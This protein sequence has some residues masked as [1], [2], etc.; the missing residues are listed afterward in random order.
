MRLGKCPPVFLHTKRIRSKTNQPVAVCFINMVQIMLI[1]AD[2]DR[3]PDKRIFIQHILHPGTAAEQL[4]KPGRLHI[5]MMIKQDQHEILPYPVRPELAHIMIISGINKMQPIRRQ[6]GN[7]FPDG[8]SRIFI[9]VPVH[10]LQI[11]QSNP[12]VRLL[13]IEAFLLIHMGKI[14]QYNRRCVR[15]FF[16][17]TF[18]SPDGAA[19]LNG[20]IWH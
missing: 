5:R 19:R 17:H 7:P 20:R 8:L 11:R 13:F 9:A 3:F 14:H 15:R 10:T 1:R 2:Y 16:L 6:P 12:A 18:P 4:P